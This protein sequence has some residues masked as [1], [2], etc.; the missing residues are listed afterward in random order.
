MGCWQIFCP[1]HILRLRQFCDSGDGSELQ[2]KGLWKFE[3]RGYNNEILE[4][5]PKAGN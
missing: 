2:N 5:T 1:N 4:H 3:F